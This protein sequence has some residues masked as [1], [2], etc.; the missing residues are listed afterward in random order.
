MTT[1]DDKERAAENKFAHDEELKFRVHAR[2]DKL[3]GLWVAEKLGR[4]GDAAEKYAKEMVLLDLEKNGEQQVLGKVEA[5]L[6]KAGVALTT[7]ALKA[8]L[9]KLHDVA[10]KQIMSE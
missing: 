7:A 8:Q 9:Q 5:D 1:F 10:L 3:F 4:T 2:R 6:K